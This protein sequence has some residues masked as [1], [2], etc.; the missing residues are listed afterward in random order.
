M[1][2]LSPDCAL[3]PR[4]RSGRV[5]D[6]NIAKAAVLKA[7]ASLNENVWLQFGLGKK[8]DLDKGKVV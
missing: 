5:R 4:A 2:S 6:N 8:K 1:L 7:S 3:S